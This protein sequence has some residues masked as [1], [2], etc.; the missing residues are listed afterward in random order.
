M[1]AVSILR[2]SEHMGARELRH[3]LTEV[4][5][6]A[7]KLVI[8]ERHNKPSKALIPYDLFLQ[9][10][11]S[12]EEARDSGRTDP[13]QDWFWS[14][15]WQKRIRRA[16]DQIKSRKYRIFESTEKALHALES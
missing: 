15:A 3:S 5:N 11:E 6:S 1:N 7:R 2:H 12:F 14:E 9:L 16:Q 8:V 4:L 10:L 13:S